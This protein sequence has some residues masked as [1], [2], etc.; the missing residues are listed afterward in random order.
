MSTGLSVGLWQGA[1]RYEAHSTWRP[2][3]AVAAVVAIFIIAAGFGLGVAE[4]V[5]KVSGTGSLSD[6]ASGGMSARAAISYTLVWQIGL[7]AGI[8]ILTLIAARLFGGN[9]RSTLALLPV[10]GGWKTYAGGFG[11]L[12]GVVMAYSLFSYL[13]AP[14]SMLSDLGPFIGMVRSELVVMLA[15]VAVIGAPLSEELLFRGFLLSALAKTRLGFM[16]AA[17]ITTAAWSA[18]HFNY[19]LLGLGAVFVTGL[20]LSWLLWRT[21]SLWVPIFCHALYNGL[22]LCVVVAVANSPAVAG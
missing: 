15:I 10:R 8:V 4:L 2:E 20:T 3:F 11:V 19:S 6:G 14:D 17:I 22:V 7:Q 12:V 9:W 13:M 16:W 18:L 1:P 21:G 5:A